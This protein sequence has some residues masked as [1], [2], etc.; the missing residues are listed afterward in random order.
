MRSVGKRPKYGLTVWSGEKHYRKG[1]PSDHCDNDETPKIPDVFTQLGIVEFLIPA[2][3]GKPPQPVE[4]ENG[5]FFNIKKSFGVAL[6]KRIPNLLEKPKLQ[7]R[8][9]EKNAKRYQNIW[10]HPVL[11]EGTRKLVNAGLGVG[12]PP[13]SSRSRRQERVR[14][15]RSCRSAAGARTCPAAAAPF[16]A[17]PPM[18]AFARD[19]PLRD[20]P[21][22]Q[23]SSTAG[24]VGF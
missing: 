18:M 17:V 11:M 10:R 15:L 4:W 19:R 7:N 12:F 2:A 6:D 9:D 14:S 1:H 21:L 22:A 5:P 23:T 13:T 16:V 3:T 8:A 24:P 20:F